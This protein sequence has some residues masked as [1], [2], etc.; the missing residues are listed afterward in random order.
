MMMVVVGLDT[1]LGIK[2]NVI[3]KPR[4]KHYIKNAMAKKR[5]TRNQKINAKRTTVQIKIS[6]ALEKTEKTILSYDPGLIRSDLTKTL[7]LTILAVA[8]IVIIYLLKLF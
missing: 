3:A 4:Y 2:L 5:R 1:I 8:G 7:V 6:K